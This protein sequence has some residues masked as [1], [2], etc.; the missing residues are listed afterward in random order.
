MK[1]EGRLASEE[2]LSRDI[3]FVRIRAEYGK[4]LAAGMKKPIVAVI[5]LRD[6][7]G[8]TIIEGIQGAEATRQFV[9]KMAR[10][11]K[12]PVAMPTFPLE[13]AHQVLG[14]TDGPHG[15][16]QLEEAAA[17]PGSIPILIIAKGGVNCTSVPEI[18]DA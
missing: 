5:D 13:E 1:D 11:K 4:A 18:D 6:P 10:E 8:R 2:F 16:K 12:L 7:K 17:V 3:G 14:P 15:R 9:E